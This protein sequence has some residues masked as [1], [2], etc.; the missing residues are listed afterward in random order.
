MRA[1]RHPVAWA[2]LAAVLVAATSG[3]GAPVPPRAWV[4]P[5]VVTVSGDEAWMARSPVF[6]LMFAGAHEGLPAAMLLRDGDLI[7][8]KNF[9]P[10]PYRTSDG[11]ALAVSKSEL[12]TILRGGL[13]TVFLGDDAAWEWLKG[14]TPEEVSALRLVG[15]QGEAGSERLDLMQKIA[16]ANPHVGLFV[17][18]G[19]ALDQALAMF[20][21]QQLWVEGVSLTVELKGRIATQSRL[22]TLLLLDC[23][24]KGL[25]FLARV[26]MLHTLI[27]GDWR[28]EKTGPLPDGL[29][30]LRSLQVQG[31]AM[32]DLSALGRL[33]RLDELTLVNVEGLTDI[34]GVADLANLRTLVLQGCG[35]VT[36]LEP[37]GDLKNLR[38]LALPPATTARQLD[39]IVRDHPDLEVLAAVGCGHITDLAPLRRLENLT[40][41]LVATPAPLGPLYRMKGLT[42]L[43]VGETKDGEDW[44]QTLAALRHALPETTVVRLA[45]L[46]LGSGWILLLLPAA[47]AAWWLARRRERRAPRR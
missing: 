34:R 13:V 28:P 2:C 22:E 16:D 8:G 21:P 40:A 6:G 27:I 5:R 20:S 1:A 15:L 29:N 7:W 31:G 18:D 30:V 38:W 26:P 3:R 11:L 23:E 47:V 37:L 25:E 44:A 33:P 36:D 14:A 35:D 41:L 39:D 12:G 45:P 17:T 42:Y 9:P 4:A 32:K 24:A 46:C 19:V 10:F 43:A